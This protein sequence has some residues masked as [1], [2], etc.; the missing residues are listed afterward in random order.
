MLRQLKYN[1]RRAQQR[2]ERYAN[3]PRKDASFA[4]EDCSVKFAPSVNR[5][6]NQK[7]AARFCGP[8]QIIQW[9]G[10]RVVAYKL[11]LRERARVHPVFHASQLKKANRNYEAVPKELEVELQ[12]DHKPEHILGR[13]ILHQGGGGRKFLVY[14]F[15]G[16]VNQEM[17]PHGRG[18]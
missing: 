12:E 2:M 4:I 13:R 7:L 6:V 14:L 1:L 15:D 3:I 16:K 8:F 18:S 17:K 5:R 11:K 9:V 10:W